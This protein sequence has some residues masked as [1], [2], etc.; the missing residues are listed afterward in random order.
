MPQDIKGKGN[1]LLETHTSS[2]PSPAT[3]LPSKKVSDL[4]RVH[5]DKSDVVFNLVTGGSSEVWVEP[6]LKLF[7]G[8]LNNF[9]FCDLTPILRGEE[10][11]GLGISVILQFLTD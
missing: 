4:P 11:M 8:F 3:S 1:E 9:S 10:G 2:L 6:A 5:I 7:W